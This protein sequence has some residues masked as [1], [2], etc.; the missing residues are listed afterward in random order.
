M[1]D[2]ERLLYHCC[3]LLWLS[4]LYEFMAREVSSYSYSLWPAEF[5][6]IENPLDQLISTK[7]VLY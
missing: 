1:N 3:V 6:G 7:V 4:P 2:D 5:Y